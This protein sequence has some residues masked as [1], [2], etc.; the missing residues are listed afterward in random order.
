[1]KHVG[2]HKLDEL[3]YILKYIYFIFFKKN[4]RNMQVLHLTKKKIKVY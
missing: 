4:L 2:I 3:C 1:M